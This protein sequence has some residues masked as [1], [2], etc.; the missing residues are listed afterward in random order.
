LFIE[1]FET[2]FYLFNDEQDVEECDATGDDSSNNVGNTIIQPYISK[3]LA[4]KKDC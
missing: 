1:T 3:E 4:N 2:H